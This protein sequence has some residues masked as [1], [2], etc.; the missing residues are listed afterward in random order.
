[1]VK[2]IKYIVLIMI[3]F[4]SMRSIYVNAHNF[5]NTIKIYDY[6]IVLTDEEKNSLKGKIDEYID[7][8]NMDMVVVIVKYYTLPTLKE[9]TDEF[10]KRNNFDKN[11]II[12]VIDTKN[13]DANIELSGNVNLYNKYEIEDILSKVKKQDKYYN[14]VERFITLSDI[15]AK[16]NETR[17]I[18]ETDN[19]SMIKNIL[20]SLIISI[21]LPAIIVL[22]LIYKLYRKS[23]INKKEYS[24]VESIIINKREDKF[25]TTNT[26]INK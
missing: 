2:N 7:K 22:V 16:T 9:Y 12:L 19:K 3:F 13:D 15:Y 18:K 25:I 1:M 23:N 20:I 8:Y 14:K 6:S 26:K 17:I 4:I 5:D 24:K 11:G 10:Y 21:V